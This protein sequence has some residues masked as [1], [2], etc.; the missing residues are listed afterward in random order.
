MYL[1]LQAGRDYEAGWS[2]MV[3]QVGKIRAGREGS[4]QRPK[5]RQVGAAS[6]TC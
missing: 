6:T 5:L 1:T 4:A 2:E 3:G